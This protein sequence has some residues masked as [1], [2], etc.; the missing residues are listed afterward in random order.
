MYVN[1][2]LHLDKVKNQ[3]LIVFTDNRAA[4]AITC[5]GSARERDL[6]R[7]ARKFW[8][9]IERNGISVWI[10]WVPTKSNPA[11]LPSR[12]PLENYTAQKETLKRIESWGL[13]ELI[14]KKMPGF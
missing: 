14:Y 1:L 8:E 5:K 10:E 3:H 4:H 11:D 6:A 13:K 2:F 12:L 7:L 9:L